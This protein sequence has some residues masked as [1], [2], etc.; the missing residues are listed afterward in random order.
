ME[1]CVNCKERKILIIKNKL[2]GRCYNYYFRNKINWN[3]NVSRASSGSGCLRKDG[4]RV[5]K[6]D[7]KRILEHT[8]VMSQLL[9]R[10]LKKNESVHHKNG[11]RH[12]NRIE[13]LELWSS[14]H[15][16]G[17]RVEDQIKW[18]KELLEFYGYQVSL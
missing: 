14:K 9:G 5:L 12:D 6:I 13:N 4:Y 11:I 3:P 16:R 7:G 15:H 18:A 2:C 1:N 17:Q 10:Q 8:H